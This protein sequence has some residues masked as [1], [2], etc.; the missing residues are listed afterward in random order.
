MSSA[1]SPAALPPGGLPTSPTRRK[2][3]AHT[4]NPST[5]L[6][7]A[8]AAAASSYVAIE[9][10]P[11]PRP[12]TPGP[13]HGG[14]H[15]DMWGQGAPRLN[16]SS[17]LLSVTSIGQ[18]RQTLSPAPLDLSAAFSSPLV[19]SSRRNDKAAHLPH[20]DLASLFPAHSASHAL[21]P[22]TKTKTTRMPPQSPSRVYR[23][24]RDLRTLDAPSP[25]PF[26][27]ASPAARTT[28]PSS[29]T[30]TAQGGAATATSA[31]A[32]SPPPTSSSNVEMVVVGVR[33]PPNPPPFP[34]GQ[35]Q[36][37]ARRY[38]QPLRHCNVEATKSPSGGVKALSVKPLEKHKAEIW[39]FAKF[40]ALFKNNP[41]DKAGKGGRLGK[42]AN[43]L[44]LPPGA[45][46]GKKGSGGQAGSGGRPDRAAAGWVKV[47]QSA[48]M[49]GKKSSGD[50]S[51]SSS[52]NQTPVWGSFQSSQ[53][54]PAAAN[55]PPGIAV[56]VLEQPTS[57]PGT[58]VERED[59]DTVSSSGP[60]SR[61]SVQ[62]E[63]R[64]NKGSRTPPPRFK[65]SDISIRED[66]SEADVSDLEERNSVILFAKHLPMALSMIREGKTARSDRHAGGESS[67]G[68]DDVDEEQLFNILDLLQTHGIDVRQ[69]LSVF[70][71]QWD[72]DTHAR[73]S[74]VSDW[75]DCISQRT[76]LYPLEEE[77]E[78]GQQHN[79]KDETHEDDKTQSDVD[80]DAFFYT[81][82]EGGLPAAESNHPPEEPVRGERRS[83]VPPPPLVTKPDQDGSSS[84]PKDGSGSPG[85]SV[86]AT[87]RRLRGQ[88]ISWLRGDTIGVGSLGRVFHGLNE[89]TGGTLAVKEVLIDPH[90]EEDKMFAE[91]LQ[92]E[93]SLLEDLQ[94]EH[95]CH[96]YGKDII[97]DRLYVYLEYMPGGSVA[98]ALEQFGAFD[99]SLI[100]TYTKQILMGLQ[101][102]HNKNIIHRDIKGANILIGLH[103]TVKLTDFGCSKRSEHSMAQTMKGSVLWMA[104][105]V[106]KGGEKGY[107]RKADIWSLGCVIVEMA[108]ARHP[109]ETDTFK[110]DN[111]LAAMFKIAMTQET[112]PI[113]SHLS[114]CCQDFLSRCFQRDPEA[115][116]EAA[117]LLEHPFVL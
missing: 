93:V 88:T 86:P 21:S 108:T 59:Q 34:H 2:Y 91:A 79:D 95:I 35:P 22:M 75:N 92:H 56:G 63:H 28:S 67:G 43:K 83:W 18:N 107:G 3:R 117:E 41:F 105:E 17:D 112:P 69:S 29:N 4:A 81:A 102:L 16:L 101:Y 39:A 38:H 30:R 44:L 52:S 96:Y 25:F 94:H 104:P 61:Q 19:L 40:M 114:V 82:R 78:Q 89:K 46:A 5:S 33:P 99:E 98:A 51:T 87:P 65:Y 6:S 116:P 55:K 42:A 57:E 60:G 106:M 23:E 58:P 10:A 14:R 115:R 7:A 49:E 12:L 111:E 37:R 76:S 97:G 32:S 1:A 73:G 71:S 103:C 31:A 113:P 77:E 26:P 11:P 15:N 24:H 64:S 20:I 70:T 13:P 110:F 66:L 54:G 62:S 53:G 47:L 74:F 48:A 27:P 85:V 80:R 36:G 8:A 50:S 90:S 68:N 9:T 100:A 72:D 84:S 45:A 109:W